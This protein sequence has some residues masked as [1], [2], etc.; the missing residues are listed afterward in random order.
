VATL[1]IGYADGYPRHVRGASVLLG[2]RRLP[3][4]GVVCMDM[5]MID[6]TDLPPDALGGPVT[7]IGRDGSEEITVDDLARW[8]GTVSYEI[9]CGISK[10]VPRV[11]QDAAITTPGGRAPTPTGAR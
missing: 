10:R 6:V 8:A 11:L 7:L 2:G 1:P 5:L 4:I 3:I 9:L